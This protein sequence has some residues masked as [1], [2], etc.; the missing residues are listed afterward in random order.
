MNAVRM[1]KRRFSY[2]WISTGDGYWE[3]ELEA[4]ADWLATYDWNT[5]C[6]DV[7]GQ[8]GDQ[9]NDEDN[10]GIREYGCLVGKAAL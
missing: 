8:R 1:W 3:L 9:H 7:E 2:R 6:H 10:P 5:E 4:R